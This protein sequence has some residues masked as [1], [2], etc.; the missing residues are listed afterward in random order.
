VTTKIERQ[1]LRDLKLVAVLTNETMTDVL[2]RLINAELE[3]VQREQKE[4][5]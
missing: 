5:R 2:K 1:S 4:K 3:R